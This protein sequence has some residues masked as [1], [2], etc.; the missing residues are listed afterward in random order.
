MAP[1]TPPRT[2]LVTG[3]S[4]GIG[5][6]IAATLLERGAPITLVARDAPRLDAAA[7]EL[8]AQHAGAHVETVAVDLT[9]P[10]AAATAV[11]AHVAAHGR[12]DVVVAN[13]GKGWVGPLAEM[14]DTDLARILPVNV[15]APFD[16]VRAALPHL[17]KAG[18]EHG[19]A[20][21]VLVASIL[22][23]RPAAGF[24]AYSASKAALVSLARSTTLEEAV[25]GV[26][27]TAV[28]PA[29][30]ATD[31]TE[32]YPGVAHDDMLPASDVA[33]AVRFLLD[34]SPGAAVPEVVIGR[35]AAGPYEP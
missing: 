7:A 33:A 3:G 6:A 2:A 29:F 19:G 4:R 9:A 13:A 5:L 10:G 8:R 27:A 23:T 11:E 35:L 24:A 30:V 26:R 22:G 12:L 20:L 34:L 17:R 25:H 18:G 32:T 21:V 15:V 14:R 28:C 16:L 31:M 1:T